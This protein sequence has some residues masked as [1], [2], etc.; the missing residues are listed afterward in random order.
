TNTV[1]TRLIDVTTIAMRWAFIGFL[2]CTNSFQS[3]LSSLAGTIAAGARK[4][5]RWVLDRTVRTEDAAVTGFW[6]KQR[7]AAGAF[8]EIEAGVGRHDFARRKT[9]MRTGEDGLEA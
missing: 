2:L 9:A 5:H 6:P 1:S 7:A 3:G 4:L 8:V